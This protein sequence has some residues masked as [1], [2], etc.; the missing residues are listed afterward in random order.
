[1][2]N[3]KIDLSSD[4]LQSL[5]LSS[6][7]SRL[8]ECLKR[9]SK[10]RMHFDEWYLG[11][12]YVLQNPYNPERFS[13]AAQTMRELLEKLPRAIKEL[14]AIEELKIDFH[15]L[16]AKLTEKHEL[17]KK[18]YSAGWLGKL[19]DD[20]LDA[21]LRSLEDYLAANKQCKPN[22]SA[23]ME[24][25][26]NY[27]IKKDPL[28]NVNDSKYTEQRTQ[29][30]THIWKSF[31]KIAHHSKSSQ[32]D[33]DKILNNCE[34][35]LL[36]LLDPTPSRD[37][38]RI[39]EILN[40]EFSQKTTDECMELLQR[41]GANRLFFFRT[42]KDP[43]WITPLEKAKLFSGI[44]NVEQLEGNQILANYWMPANFLRKAASKD[45]AAV[46][47]LITGLPQTNNPRVLEEFCWIA[48]DVSEISTSL[49]LKRRVF[50]YCKA[51]FHWFNVKLL[52]KI[53]L[54][55]VQGSDES[56]KAA[57]QILTDL[58]YS[59]NSWDYQEF[60]KKGLAESIEFCPKDVFNKLVELLDLILSQEFKQDDEDGILYDMSE[61]WCPSLREPEEHED[62]SKAILARLIFKSGL[63]IC[64]AN[65]G[66]RDSIFDGLKSK[67]W[68]IFHRIHWHLLSENVSTWGA[69]YLSAIIFENMEV[70]SKTEYVFEF[71][72]LL[73]NSIAVYG[74]RIFTTTLLSQ[75]VAMIRSGPDK[76]EYEKCR[77]DQYTEEKFNLSRRYVHRQMLAPFEGI[78]DDT[79]KGYFKELM[80]DLS[81]GPF[82]GI[83]EAS[84]RSMSGFVVTRSPKT[85]EELTLMTDPD[86]LSLFNEWESE[87]ND[88]DNWLI[89]YK[90][91]GLAN[92]FKSLLATQIYPNPSRW[93]FWTL[94]LKAIERPIYVESILESGK[95]LI[96]K[97]DY[98]LLPD[99]FEICHWVIDH[100]DS[101][102]SFET[103]GN[104]LSRTKPNWRSTRRG[105]L[106]FVESLV[107]KDSKVSCSFRY[108]I[109]EVLAKICSEFD[110][111]LDIE[112]KHPNPDYFSTA[113]NCTRSRALSSV[114][115]TGFWIRSQIPEDPLTDVFLILD[116]RLCSAIKMT[117]PEFAIF[118]SEI[119]RLWNLNKAWATQ[120]VVIL[121]PVNTYDSWI[122]SFGTYLRHFS[123][124]HIMFEIL[125]E[126]Y[127]FAV[128]QIPRIS[129][130]P[131]QRN[132]FVKKLGEHIARQYIYGFVSIDDD[133]L[134]SSYYQK[135]DFEPEYKRTLFGHIG[136]AIRNGKPDAEMQTR[137][138]S[139]FE[140][141]LLKNA[142]ECED[143]SQWL[144]ADSL[145]LTW[146][147][148]AYKKILTRQKTLTQGIYSEVEF[149]RNNLA[150]N[151]LIIQE[152]LECIANNAQPDSR[153]LFDEDDAVFIV[154]AGLNSQNETV[155]EVAQRTLNIFLSKAFFG[156]SSIV[157]PSP[158][159]DAE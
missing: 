151:E 22:R 2:E 122:A 112:S 67:R 150:E 31:E 130:D 89:E 33:F 117:Q 58:P 137:I 75:I 47:K 90:I 48:N 59:S 119:H 72:N 12:L 97:G 6:Q 143:F 81:L 37:I 127:Q 41:S 91:S 63:K 1:M 44:E 46:I 61:L 110:G 147:L 120:K 74:D 116:R 84:K 39:S 3:D 134:L 32:E 78:L 146:R 27:S 132:D 114:I 154:Q 36:G 103:S 141:R 38:Q 106:D 142:D 71:V 126:S 155:R 54:K 52:S 157:I 76:K 136:W 66:N 34:Q 57:F 86:L 153:S 16:R 104:S 24:G 35:V 7:Q 23:Q 156:F 87:Y 18:G 135:S 133:D 124:N 96:A 109:I 131:R 73:R 95:E 42:A 25:L 159:S 108:Q 105:V 53:F 98:T 15:Q 56:R 158:L 65:D 139:F 69:D 43:I 85:Q 49:E 80:N 113:I 64:E 45:S 68:Q 26:V 4:R 111:H 138:I 83:I 123:S 144:S 115:Q 62:S 28:P 145:E 82:K 102:E 30:V 21:S 107:A 129:N 101:L 9:L 5:E 88:P 55:W 20:P 8:L 10:E 70:F 50:A 121:F 13:Q 77:G 118:G 19:I 99:L 100:K 148:N 29:R 152:C 92:E 51:P 128:S 93:A 140:W 40:S 14:E 149:L 11:A 79:T 94:N 17:A 60:L 125:K